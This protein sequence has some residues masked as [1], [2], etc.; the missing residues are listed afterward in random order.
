MADPELIKREFIFSRSK[1]GSPVE[2]VWGEQHGFCE[3]C[4]SFGEGIINRRW[5]EME[6]ASLRNS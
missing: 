2:W 3:T 4:S 6:S 5:A 1:A